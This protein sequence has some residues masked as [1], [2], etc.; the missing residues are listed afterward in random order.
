[1]SLAVGATERLPSQ[2]RKPVKIL[3]S[4][5]QIGLGRGG[6]RLGLSETQRIQRLA[7][8]VQRSD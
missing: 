2:P 8:N 1:M 5:K 3:Y 4:A 7:S 6:D